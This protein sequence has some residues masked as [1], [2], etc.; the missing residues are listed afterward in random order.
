VFLEIEPNILPLM[1]DVFGNYVI[2]KFYEHGN[3]AQKKILAEKMKGKVVWLSQDTY[4]CRVVQ[5]V[6]A[7]QYLDRLADD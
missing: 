6:G 2:Q 3:Q 1:R 7:T 4:A 5:K